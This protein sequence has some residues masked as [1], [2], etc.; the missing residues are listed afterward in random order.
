MIGIYASK[1]KDVRRWHLFLLSRNCARFYLSNTVSYLFRDKSFHAL[2]NLPEIGKDYISTRWFFVYVF[3]CQ[4]RKKKW[5]IYSAA[6]FFVFPQAI[7][8]FCKPF[9]V[10]FLVLSNFGNN[11]CNK[12]SWSI[13]NLSPVDF[14]SF[15][16]MYVGINRFFAFTPYLADVGGHNESYII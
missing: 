3:S 7:Y 1:K 6:F 5:L 9:I 10:F 16:A 12:D 8:F 13:L 2:T 15:Q 4:Y 11:F 14:Q